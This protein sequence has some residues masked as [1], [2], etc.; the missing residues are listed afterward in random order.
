MSDCCPSDSPAA[1]SRPD[2]LLW[3]SGI[4]VVIGYLLFWLLPER[5]DMPLWLATM[6][7]GIFELVNKMWL[8]LVAAVVFVGLLERIPRELVM[9]A[10][11][12]GGTVKGILR[13]TLA[14]VALDLCSH[15]ILMIGA[16]LYERGASIGQL[17]AF[18]IASPW[19]SLSLTII[20]I[21]LIGWQWTLLFIALSMVIGI[22]T[23]IFFDGL[24]VRGKLPPNP[25]KIETPTVNMLSLWPGIVRLIKTA[26]YTPRAFGSLLIDGI[27]DSRMVFRW[28]LFGIVLAV[29]IRAMVPLDLYQDYFG[30]TVA[31]LML[32]LLAATIIE[33]C[34]EGSTPIAADLLT[35]AAA[36]G[37]SFTFLMAGVATDYTEIM[38]LRDV[39]K[40]WKIALF[41]PLIT[42]PQVLL[43]GWILNMA[44][45]G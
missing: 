34:S 30:P 33:V 25:H 8:G 23:G 4:T 9:S 41:L 28:L 1:K 16:K 32:T 45:L 29:L 18:L 26:E 12:Q 40:S 6:S 42:L 27:R 5:V 22:V 11:G 43:I 38:V 44:S 13:A 20:M 10:L 39:T 15:G 36:P 19:N 14:G 3:C 24:V 17:M 21:S 7:E 35:R 2:Y 31:G 37:N